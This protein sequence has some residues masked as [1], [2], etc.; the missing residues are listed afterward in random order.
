M[1]L[2]SLIR[3]S[4][5]ES[6]HA[7]GQRWG[8][9]SAPS[10]LCS[11][12][13]SQDRA[14]HGGTL[15]HAGSTGLGPRG[16]C[17][18]A[19]PGCAWRLWEGCAG[20]LSNSQGVSGSALAQGHPAS[21]AAAQEAPCGPPNPAPYLLPRLSAAPCGC[22]SSGPSPGTLSPA[23]FHVRGLCVFMSGGCLP[24]WAGGGGEDWGYWAELQL[25]PHRAR[26]PG[27]TGNSLTKSLYKCVR[28]HPKSVTCP[29]HH[30]GNSVP[31]SVSRS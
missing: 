27:A 28:L 16:G 26:S 24:S 12:R 10:S 13:R 20:K 30:R 23:P 14:L 31:Q 18:L 11:S 19:G 6:Q 22:S 21:P 1:P 25:L 5:R 7:R 15:L 9:G 8:W 2:P 29:L 4:L 3:R 17:S